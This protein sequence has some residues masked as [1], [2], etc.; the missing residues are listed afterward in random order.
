[1]LWEFNDIIT[2]IYCLGYGTLLVSLISLLIL[3]KALLGGHSCFVCV[4]I[5]GEHSCFV[6]VPQYFHCMF[7]IWSNLELEV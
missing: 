7:C 1:M 4:R 5:V 3:L 6:T 2:L